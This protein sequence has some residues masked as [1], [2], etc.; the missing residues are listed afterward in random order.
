MNFNNYMRFCFFIAVLLFLNACTFKTQEQKEWEKFAENEVSSRIGEKLYL[1]DSCLIAGENGIMPF[2][3][4]GIKAK[5]RIVTY[6]DISCSAC[7]N[8]F[9]LWDK[10]FQT[11]LLNEKNEVV[12]IGDPT[13]NEKLKDLYMDVLLNKGE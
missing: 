5:K 12:L 6:I 11:A 10:R 1:P 2:Y 8:N 13:V 3:L 4:S 9:S 7:L